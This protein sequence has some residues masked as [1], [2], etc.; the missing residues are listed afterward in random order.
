M[1]SSVLAQDRGLLELLV[2]YSTGVVF[3]YQQALV[4]ASLPSADR[5][6]LERY[7]A[8]ALEMDGALRRALT[9]AG[10]TPPPRPAPRAPA[11]KTPGTVEVQALIREEEALISG[12]YAALQKLADMH[13]VAG[14]A[15]Y[16]AAGGRRLVVLRR[17]AGQPLL[18]GAFETGA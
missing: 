1:T 9:Q 2:G 5:P 18:P 7:R 16:M 8:A 11:S 13:L 6:V 15:A 10:G 17:I 14:A 4:D 12:W 3:A